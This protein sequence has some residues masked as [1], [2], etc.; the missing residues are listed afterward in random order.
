MSPLQKKF[1]ARLRALHAHCNKSDY[2]C[3]A[4]WLLIALP[5]RLMPKINIAGTTSTVLLAAVL[6]DCA[7]SRQRVEAW[8]GSIDRHG[9]ASTA[10]GE[11]SQQRMKCRILSA[12]E[13]A[14]KKRLSFGK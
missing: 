6:N 9:E 13:A 4:Q 7:I 14:M 5:K 11:R 2:S 1:I 10:A 12:I 8:V 3:V